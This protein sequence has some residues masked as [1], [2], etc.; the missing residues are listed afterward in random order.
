[1]EK[2]REGNRFYPGV[3]VFPMSMEF[4]LS[5]KCEKEIGF[6]TMIFFIEI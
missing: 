3:E 5:Q 2:E 1:L 6:N 4:K